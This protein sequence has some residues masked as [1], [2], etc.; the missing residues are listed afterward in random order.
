MENKFLGSEKIGVLLKKFAI[1]CIFSLVISALYNIVDQIFIGNSELGYLGNAATSVVFPVTIIST[2]FAWCFG[3]GFAALLSIRQGQKETK[4]LDK[5]AGN[6]IISTI[7]A[8]ILFF[9]ACWIFK[10][11][12]LRLFGASDQT[13]GLALAYFKII[14]YMTIP[15]MLANA[16][17]STIRSDGAPGFSMAVTVTGA[18][19]NIIFGPICIYVLGWGIEGAAIAT[20]FGQFVSF[21]LA[22]YY[23][24]RKAKTFKLTKASF[25]PS[26]KE[27]WSFTKLGISTFITQISIVAISLACNIALVKY[28]AGSKYGIDIPI[29]VMGIAMKVFTVVIN[30]IVG[31]ILGAQPI[32]GYNLGAG[33]FERVRK[34]FRLVLGW[35]IGIA[36]VFLAIFELCPQI[37]I[38]IFG[39]ANEALYM[40]FAVKLFRIFF[41]LLVA[42]CTNKMLSIFFQAV[43]QPVKASIASLVRDIVCFV[44]LCFIVPEI[45]G[46]N[47]EGCLWAA[48]IADVVGIIIS[49]TF[50]ISYFKNL[51][52]SA[53]QSSDT[54]VIRE[55]KPGVIIAIAREHGSAGKEIG[56]LV[57]K[58]LKIPFYHKEMLAV[59]AKQSG[60]SKKYLSEMNSKEDESKLEYNLFLTTA[61]AAYAIE[62]Q[63]AAVKEIAKHGSCVIVGRAAD[64]IL[65]NNKNIV[66]VFIT[67]PEAYR[68]EKLKEM[69]GDNPTAAKK[70]I[71]KSDHNRAKYYKM[72]SG[73]EWGKREN[74]DLVVDSSIGNEAAA[75]VIAEYAKAK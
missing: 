19:L 45:M 71:K 3:D 25:V 57:A 4:G 34:T 10:E 37:V 66:R 44:P 75:R 20:I 61:P 14:L 11:P 32:L 8:A 58:E 35:T 41:L 39:S 67:A 7:I 68:V 72:V 55:S 2:A 73:Q 30:I 38:N 23:W 64:Y 50:A 27:F 46:G 6:L 5:A 63:G 1:P 60:L 70:S 18:V 40:E 42:T 21:V 69:Y 65:R 17:N 74:Y 9:A 29:A 36:A 22:T 31:L 49:G 54:S 12:I 56:R 51:E 28:G 52:A 53:E 48:P 16:M 15:N 13:I 59:A 47:I 62:A 26:W 24:T 33:N 43:G